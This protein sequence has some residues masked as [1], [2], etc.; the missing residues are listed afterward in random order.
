[1]WGGGGWLSSESAVDRCGIA[2]YGKHTVKPTNEG[3]RE[4]DAGEVN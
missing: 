3:E 2:R 1:M 4:R